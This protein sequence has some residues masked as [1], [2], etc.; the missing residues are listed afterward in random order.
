MVGARR[1]IYWRGFLGFLVRS[2][3]VRQP[4]THAQKQTDTHGVGPQSLYMSRDCSMEIIPTVSQ[5]PQGTAAAVMDQNTAV[6]NGNNLPSFSH[7][8]S[9]IAAAIGYSSVQCGYWHS[10]DSLVVADLILRLFQRDFSTLG[11][12]CVTD[13]RTLLLQHLT[14]PAKP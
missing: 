1:K 14:V 12:S 2:S 7:C 8:S 6:S 5:N 4:S 11:H 10:A 3:V 9:Q 13:V